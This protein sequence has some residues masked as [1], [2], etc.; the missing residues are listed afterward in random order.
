MA[1]TQTI[2]VISGK[3]NAD[4]YSTLMVERASLI[5]LARTAAA[6]PAGVLRYEP[7]LVVLDS[8]VDA[9]GG[10]I[11]LRKIKMLRPDLPV[12]FLTD[13]SSEETV[14]DAFKWGARA[15]FCPPVNLAELQQTVKN[16]L[17]LKNE[18]RESRAS[19]QLITSGSVTMPGNLPANLPTTIGRAIMHIQNNFTQPMYLEDLARVAHL[20]KFHFCRNFKQYVGMSPMRFVT[21]VKIKKAAVLLQQADFNISTV[22]YKLGFSDLSEFTRQF[23]NVFG[24]P[25]SA[26]RRSHQS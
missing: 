5:V 7:D 13:V 20:S 23:K 3:E 4:R 12:I 17:L 16:L 6:H 2:V 19:L 25:P 11:I 8:G 26:Y 10:V 15:Y 22:A 21:M 18:S 9:A 14:I 1:N 24:I